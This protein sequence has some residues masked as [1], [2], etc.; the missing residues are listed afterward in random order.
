MTLGG[1]TMK[2]GARNQVS[3]TV[4]SIKRGTVMAQVGLMIPAQSTMGSVMTLDSLDEL[5]VR[6]GDQVKLV[7]KAINV[8]VVKEN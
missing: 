3:A 5:G 8:L 2:Y 7:I 6:E 1:I 4:T